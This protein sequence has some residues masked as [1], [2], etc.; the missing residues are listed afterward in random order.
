LPDA[1]VL[2]ARSVAEAQ[3]LLSEYR[4][5]FFILDV[6]L[7]DGSGTDFLCDVQTVQPEARVMMIT[8]SPLPEHEAR[9]REL[10]VLLFRQKP[11][12][13]KEIV[14]L[15]QSHYETTGHG[16]DTQFASGQFA[17]SLTCLS[18][19]DIIQLKC[20]SEATVILQVASPSG[21]GRIYFEAGRI[22]HAETPDA[23]G[24]DAFVHIL[25]WK[26]GRI[27]EMT[28]PFQTQRTIT[29]GWQALLLDAC[30]RIDETSPSNFSH[31]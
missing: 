6:N 4:I 20:I 30:Q 15:V 9:S 2:T 23:T 21:N 28:E 14:R 18:V 22:I 24:E 1:E 13:P 31:H 8:A 16:T 17:V 29:V 12:D 7:P 3:L 26:G 27:K 25:R 19:V 10:G 11:V 5:Q